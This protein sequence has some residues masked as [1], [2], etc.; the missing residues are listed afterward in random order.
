M[1]FIFV[2]YCLN[3]LYGIYTDLKELLVFP[4]V[5]IKVFKE[6]AKQYR[7]LWNAPRQLDTSSY[8]GKKITVKR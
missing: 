3:S 7:V 8:R 4:Q 6:E 1:I 2:K 5:I